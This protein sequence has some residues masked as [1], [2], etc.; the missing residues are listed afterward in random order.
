MAYHWK[1]WMGHKPKCESNDLEVVPVD[2]VHFSS[3]LYGLA[4]GMQL[5]VALLF[6]EV[7]M[8]RRLT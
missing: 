7:F 1:I 8:R 6:G 3:A 5:S 4:I 2:I